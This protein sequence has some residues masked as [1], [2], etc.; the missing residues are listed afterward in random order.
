MGAAVGAGF[1][2]FESA[3]YAYSCLPE[4][5]ILDG[6]TVSI[7]YL[8][9]TILRYLIKNILLRGLFSI[10]G[11]VLYCAPYASI[12][13]RNMGKT[14]NVFR[15]VTSVDLWAVFAISCVCHGL[16]NHIPDWPSLLLCFAVITVIL[17]GAALYD[18]RRNFAQLA[19][20]IPQAAASTALT[21]LQIRG[22]RG[23]HAGVIFSVTHPEILI[24]S[25]SSCGLSYPVGMPDLAPIHAKILVSGGG[26]YLGDM[27][28]CFGS[29]VNGV[30]VKPMTAVFLKAGDR[31]TLGK[32]QEFEII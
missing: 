13:A 22:I 20:G 2:A 19:K 4:I 10:C 18:I 3:Q 8:D 14:G 28:S 29:F 16:W 6:W 5:H 23:I 26:L 12:A 21:Q 30:P 15:S 17:W 11:H 32:D 27:G 1:S 25:D 24:G 9:K 31:F 7:L